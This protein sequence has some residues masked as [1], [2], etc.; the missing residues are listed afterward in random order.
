L[1]DGIAPLADGIAPLADG[2]A[3]LADG[4]RASLAAETPSPAVMI[5]RGARREVRN[6]SPILVFM[7][8]R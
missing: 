7:V 2:I 4:E 8:K 5:E 1:A 3:S 6:A